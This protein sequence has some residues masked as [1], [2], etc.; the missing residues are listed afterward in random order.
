MTARERVLMLRLH[1]KLK[2]SPKLGKTLGITAGI[3]GYKQQKGGDD[4]T[5]S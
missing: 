2:A 3:R 1:E 4:G 5:H